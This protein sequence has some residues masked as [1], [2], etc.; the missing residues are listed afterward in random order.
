V[1]PF[2]SSLKCDA[3]GIGS[4]RELMTHTL[5]NT[6]A[7]EYVRA[8]EA[9]LLSHLRA[10]LLFTVAVSVGSESYL[11]LRRAQRLMPP[12]QFVSAELRRDLRLA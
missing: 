2:S 11:T 6:S 7:L 12:I 1:A 4:A 10:T 3:T 8:V 9:N 5:A